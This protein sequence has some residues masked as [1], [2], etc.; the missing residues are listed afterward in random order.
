MR[1][2][3]MPGLLLLAS[4]CIALPAVGQNSGSADR[5]GAAPPTTQAPQDPASAPA[6]GPLPTEHRGS[7]SSPQSGAAFEGAGDNFGRPDGQ[8]EGAQTSPDVGGSGGGAG[9][10]FPNPNQRSGSGAGR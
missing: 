3:T 8:G 7:P 1:S 10:S 2:I 9:G 6:S 5:P 4:A